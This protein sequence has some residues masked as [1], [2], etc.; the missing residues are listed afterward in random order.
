MALL[1]SGIVP[2]DSRANFRAESAS[3]IL[4][5]LLVSNAQR[6]C[7]ECTDFSPCH[8]C[9]HEVDDGDDC[10]K[11]AMED[12]M[13]VPMEDASFPDSVKDDNKRQQLVAQAIEIC[14]KGKN[15]EMAWWWYRHTIEKYEMALDHKGLEDHDCDDKKKKKKKREGIIH[16]A[17]TT[18]IPTPD[19]TYTTSTI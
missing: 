13:Y 14:N 2:G 6:I 16:N 9:K 3:Q 1:E 12:L 17:H 15:T 7:K 4:S 19:N 5:D 11:K 10:I 8:S 18:Q